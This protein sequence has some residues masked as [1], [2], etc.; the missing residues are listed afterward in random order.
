VKDD[1]AASEIAE[2]GDNLHNHDSPSALGGYMLPANGGYIMSQDE[3]DLLAGR[4]MREKAEA[5]RKLDQLIAKAGQLGARLTA[6]GEMLQQSPQN[7]MFEGISTN[8]KYVSP[9]AGSFRAHEVNGKEIAELTTAIRD[10]MEEVDR[11]KQRAE[12]LGV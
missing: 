7:V 4:T 2:L 5:K 9:G 6:L 10:A 1:V 11:V 3:Q 12:R 8:I